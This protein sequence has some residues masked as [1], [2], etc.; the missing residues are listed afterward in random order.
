MESGDSQLERVGRLETTGNEF[1]STHAPWDWSLRYS[2]IIKRCYWQIDALPFNIFFAVSLRLQ[3]VRLMKNVNASPF[4]SACLIAAKFTSCPF[5]SL[6][7]CFL[8]SYFVP[9]KHSSMLFWHNVLVCL[10]N[11]I[12]PMTK[13]PQHTWDGWNWVRWS[14][15]GASRSWSNCLALCSVL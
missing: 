6:T 2:S 5:S 14:L 1:A 13:S 11:Q 8:S 7:P 4:T 15:G 9:L 12:V 3:S 10:D